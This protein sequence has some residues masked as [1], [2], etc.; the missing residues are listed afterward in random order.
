MTTSDAT[1]RD[2][3]KWAQFRST[4]RL[5]RWLL[6]LL[7]TSWLAGLLAHT[8]LKAHLSGL[9]YAFIGAFAVFAV[10]TAI[11]EGWLM[12]LRCPGC[13]NCFFYKGVF[14][15]TFSSKCRHCALPLYAELDDDDTIE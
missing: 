1:T 4:K 13:G 10:S 9:K 15:N 2:A 5:Q 12:H 14:R 11:I 8:V 3:Q 7:A 6:G